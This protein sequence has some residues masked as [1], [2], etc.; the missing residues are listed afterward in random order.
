M[1]RKADL[2][3]LRGERSKL[4][5]PGAAVAGSFF[6]YNLMEVREKLGSEKGVADRLLAYYKRVNEHNKTAFAERLTEPPAKG[7]AAYLG[8]EACTECH[9]EERKVWDESKH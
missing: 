2:E 1:P 5:A 8:V 6:R 9:D 4:E 7:Q 3:R